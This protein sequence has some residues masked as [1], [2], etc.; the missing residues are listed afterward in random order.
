MI[1]DEMKT[2]KEK[3]GVK[4]N[5]ELE[6]VEFEDESN[7]DVEFEEVVDEADEEPP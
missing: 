3:E 7:D 1:K 4:K 2:I 6:S 5:D